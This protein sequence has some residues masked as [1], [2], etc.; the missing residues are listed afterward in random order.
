MIDIENAVYTLIANDLESR[1]TGIKI[2]SSDARIPTQFPCVS[3]LEADN[4]TYVNTM[5]SGGEEHCEVMFEVNIY[6]QNKNVTSNGAK[7][8]A[9]NILKAVDDIMMLK[10]FYRVMKNPV[11]MEDATIIRL[12]ARYKGIV[13]KNKT[14]YRR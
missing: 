9:K 8:E 12:I 5:D 2:T 14:I 7:G 11:S 4:S 3:F 13:D 6:T 10:G 1:F